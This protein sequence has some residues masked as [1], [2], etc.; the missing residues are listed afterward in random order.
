MSIYNDLH[1]SIDSNVCLEACNKSSIKQLGTCC[2]TVRHGKQ[3]GLCHFFIVPDYCHQIL[4]LNDIHA[5]N[6]I[7]SLPCH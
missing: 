1:C 5:L 7:Y 6:L 4:G 2:L 3:L